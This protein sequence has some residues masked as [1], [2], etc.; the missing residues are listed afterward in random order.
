MWICSECLDILLL[1]C[2]LIFQVYLFRLFWK[3][4]ERRFLI[5][6]SLAFFPPTNDSEV[7]YSFQSYIIQAVYLLI[8]TVTQVCIVYALW[9]GNILVSGQAM[10]ICPWAS[11]QRLY[12]HWRKR[13]EA[14][15]TQKKKKNEVW[16]DKN[17]KGILNWSVGLLLQIACQW[18]TPKLWFQVFTGLTLS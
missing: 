8:L 13:G 11:H 12:P 15:W 14:P 10:L 5:N 6:N 2:E 7:K 1:K 16:R 3:S 17:G 4:Y 18:G 9:N